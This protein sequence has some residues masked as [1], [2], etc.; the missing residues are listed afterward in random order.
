MWRSHLLQVMMHLMDEEE[1]MVYE[2]EQVTLL[3]LL[4]LLPLKMKVKVRRCQRVSYYSME[5]AV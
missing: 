3:S 4:S 5:R 1:P 2:E